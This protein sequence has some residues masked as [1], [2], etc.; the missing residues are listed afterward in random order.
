MGGVKTID[1]CKTLS[2]GYLSR[3][4]EFAR[5]F[6]QNYMADVRHCPVHTDGLGDAKPEVIDLPM[7]FRQVGIALGL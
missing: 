3:N 2:H 1:L 4:T 6:D 7:F 5:A